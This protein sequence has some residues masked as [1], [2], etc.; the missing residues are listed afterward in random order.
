MA[1]LEPIHWD[2]VS[3]EM[4]ELLEFLGSMSF[5]KRFYLAGGTA[6]ALQLGHRIS[7]DLD[8]F[9]EKDEVHSKTRQEIVHA[10][11][12]AGFLVDI[13]ENVDGNLLLMINQTRVGFF[14]YGYPL[15]EP[16]FDLDGCPLAGLADI[17][18][19]KLDAVIS[20]GSRKDFYDLFEIAKHFPLSELLELG[21]QKY[22]NM[23]DFPMMAVESMIFFE[24][25]D[26]D[27]QPLLL[28][29]TSWDQVREYFIDQVK[30]LGKQW[31]FS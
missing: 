23:R 15:L 31:F 26:R 16:I 20:R 12:S 28:K 9:A 19:M 5:L 8:F 17:G 22:P 24:N 14:G 25:A 6:L 13:I 27:V 21:D 4:R 18:L 1:L 7:V 29:E 10:V 30:T 2:A 11:G 3:K